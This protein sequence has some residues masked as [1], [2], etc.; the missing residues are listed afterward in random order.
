MERFAFVE[1]P[2]EA[3]P[4]LCVVQVAQS[5]DGFDEAPVFLDGFGELVLST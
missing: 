1:L 5:G 3:S 4:V 2:M